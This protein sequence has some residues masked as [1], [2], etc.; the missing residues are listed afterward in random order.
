MKEKAGFELR[1]VEREQEVVAQLQ[2]QSQDELLQQ[3]IASIYKIISH[4]CLETQVMHLGRDIDHHIDIEE[5]GELEL[6]EFSL[7]MK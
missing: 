1:H 3:K 7:M 2:A 4:L 5:Q 6:N